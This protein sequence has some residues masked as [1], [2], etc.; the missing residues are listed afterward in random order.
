MAKSIDAVVR[1]G[2]QRRL[3]QGLHRDR[4]ARTGVSLLVE[5]HVPQDAQG[6]AKAFTLERRM[7]EVLPFCLTGRFRCG[8]DVRGG[9]GFGHD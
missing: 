3:G 6:L 7:I 4:R 8:N 9:S 2:N 1:R 5:N